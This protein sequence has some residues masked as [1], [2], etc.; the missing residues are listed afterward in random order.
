MTINLEAFQ[1]LQVEDV[2]GL[3]RENGP[4]VCVFPI[5]GTRRWY[6][7]ESGPESNYMELVTRRHIEIYRMLFRHG[8]DSLLAPMFGPDLMERGPEYVQMA[9]EGLARLTN[10]PDFLQFYRECGLRVHFYGDYRKALSST[11]HAPVCDLFDQVTRQTAGNT[12][13][14][15][16]YGVF[17]NNATGAIAE[18]AIDYHTRY[19]RSPQERE[20]VEMYYGE[21]LGPASLFIGFDKFS[22]FDMPMVGTDNTDLYFTASPSL[23]F[24]ERQ[25][26]AI[27]YDHLFSRRAPEPDYDDLSPQAKARLAG[28]YH[29][30]ADT[31][32][33]LGTLQDGIWYPHLAGRDDPTGL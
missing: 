25:L 13:G 15:L 2:A 33:G 18:L 17:A 12:G 4:V 19:R 3:V 27:L 5:N 26:R 11:P 31:T 8:I 6:L 22:A 16:F 9:V 21:Y 1:A 7:L 32:F 29:A 30:N 10:L 23:Y 14:A 24:S 28:F 20:L